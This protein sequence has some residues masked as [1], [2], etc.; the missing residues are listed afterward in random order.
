MTIKKN[1]NPGLAKAYTY[2]KEPNPGL[3]KVHTKKDIKTSGKHSMSDADGIFDCMEKYGYSKRQASSEY[4]DPEC[5]EGVDTI[6]EHARV[7]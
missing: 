7:K 1:P 3:V 5:F 6:R 2:G 4:L